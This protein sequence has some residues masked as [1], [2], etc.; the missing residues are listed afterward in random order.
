M[1]TI[2]VNDIVVAGTKAEFD[3]LREHLNKSSPINNLRNLKHFVGYAFDWDRR[4]GT[5]IVLQFACIERLL[6]RVDI[7][8][9]SNSFP[10]CRVVELRPRQAEEEEE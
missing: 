8:A 10:A 9:E 1:M 3:G 7:T 6:V 2:H 4:L 5:M